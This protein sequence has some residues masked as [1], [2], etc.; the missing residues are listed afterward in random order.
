MGNELIQEDTS[1]WRAKTRLPLLM[2]GAFF[3]FRFASRRVFSGPNKAK[4]LSGS[5]DVVV[6]RSF[7]VC[8]PRAEVYTFW[9]NYRHYPTFQAPNTDLEYSSSWIAEAPFHSD[10]SL[11]PRVIELCEGELVAWEASTETG[12]TNSGKVEFYDS[13]LAYATEV[14]VTL[15]YSVENDTEDF[16]QDIC[17]ESIEQELMK[18]KQVM[19]SSLKANS[20]DPKS[21]V[22]EPDCDPIYSQLSYSWMPG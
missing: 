21:F 11:E 15:K 17:E 1:K 13:A 4:R 2:A 12:V 6:H 7:T 22:D 3:L 16:S 14:R 19:E 8:L 10:K 20:K 9:R 5:R 18:F